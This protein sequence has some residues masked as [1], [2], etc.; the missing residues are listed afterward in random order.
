MH[1]VVRFNR[2]AARDYDIEMVGIHDARKI[3]W[4]DYLIA[5]GPISDIRKL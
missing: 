3:P 5:V 1:A 2:V 4:S